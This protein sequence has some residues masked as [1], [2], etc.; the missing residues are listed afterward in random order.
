MSAAELTGR[1][2]QTRPADSAGGPAWLFSRNVDLSVFLGSAALSFAALWIGST[3]GVLNSDTPDWAWIPAV[4][5]ID[6]AHVWSTGFRVYLD[7]DE[8]RRRKV[9]YGLVPVIGLAI[10]I[11]LY[12]EG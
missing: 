11:A 6:V 8:F 10:G 7:S 4:L 9:L 2:L 1:Q 3:A 12:S 5:L